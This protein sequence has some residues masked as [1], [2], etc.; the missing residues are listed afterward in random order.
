MQLAAH[1]AK[2]R[3]LIVLD[4]ITW[5]GSCD[6]VFLGKLKIA[7]DLYFKQNHQLILIISGSNSAWI[8]DNI[9]NSTGFFGRISLRIHLEELPLSE[10]MQF[11]SNQ[12]KHISPYEI[13][14]LLSVTGGVPRYLEELRY[15]ISAEQNIDNLCFK[16]SGL[17]FHEFGEIFSDIFNK[18]TDKYLSIVKFLADHKGT[19]KDITEH[20]KRISGGDISEYLSD[21]CKSDFIS[22]DQTWKLISGA[23]SRHVVYR[24]KD[25]YL[26]FYL[27]YIEPNRQKILKGGSV[28]DSYGW[29]TILGLQ[30]ENLV[31]NNLPKIIQELEIKPHEIVNAGPYHQTATKRRKKCQIDLLIQTKYRCLY[32][33]EIKFKNSAIENKVIQEMKDKIACLEIPKGFSI[34]PVLIHVNGICDTLYETDFFSH[35]IDFES[36]IST[37]T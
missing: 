18:K 5:M 17:L 29:S 28:K 31:L 34:R 27:K 9:I 33:C 3:V 2:G 14:K 22:A 20:L 12:S 4:E 11:W 32:L 23:P 6:T 25:N 19:Q 26:R 1:C 15:D 7:W 21:L 16:K 24:I 35:I 8:E 37:T 13:F 30:F 10:C 36:L